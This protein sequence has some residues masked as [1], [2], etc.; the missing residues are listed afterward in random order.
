M[1]RTRGGIGEIWLRER[2][3]IYVGQERD[4]RERGEKA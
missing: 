3:K 2:S 1:R 4:M